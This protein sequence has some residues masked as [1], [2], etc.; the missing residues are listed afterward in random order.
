MIEQEQGNVAAGK[1]INTVSDAV[2]LIYDNYAETADSIMMV[3]ML[4]VRMRA[5]GGIVP[6]DDKDQFT[7][8]YNSAVAAAK[9]AARTAAAARIALAT[10]GETEG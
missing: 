7:K 2:E 5:V 6:E 10:C 3:R 9:S 4:A 8:I 1:R